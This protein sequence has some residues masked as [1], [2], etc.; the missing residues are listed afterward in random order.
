MKMI[1]EDKVRC[2]QCLENSGIQ[3]IQELGSGSFGVV[4]RVKQVEFNAD[5]EYAMKQIKT[6]SGDI[7]NKLAEALQT[8]HPHCIRF[9]YCFWVKHEGEDFGHTFILME[10][11]SA[12]TL[13]HWIKENRENPDYNLGDMKKWIWQM[14]SALE[15]LNEK[16]VIHRD[17]S[18][19]NVFFA[20]EA[21]YK[22]GGSLKVADYGMIYKSI[23][24]NLP[25]NDYRRSDTQDGAENYTAP[26]V[27]DGHEYNANADV[28]SLGMIAV[29]L[30][31]HVD[32]ME[33][34]SIK[35]QLSAGEI[36]ECLESQDEKFKDF[37]KLATSPSNKRPLANDLIE[38]DFLSGCEVK[39]GIPVY[40]LIDTLHKLEDGHQLSEKEQKIR[41]SVWEKTPFSVTFQDGTV[42]RL[43][44][45]KKAVEELID[46]ETPK[47]LFDA[48]T[49]ILTTVVALTGST[50]VSVQNTVRMPC[51]EEYLKDLNSY[52]DRVKDQNLIFFGLETKS[53]E[54]L[55]E[56][57]K[58]GHVKLIPN[59]VVWM[60]NGCKEFMRSVF[61]TNGKIQFTNGN[62]RFYHMPRKNVLKYENS[63]HNP[64]DVE[65]LSFSKET[66]GLILKAPVPIEP[67]L[68][69]KRIKN[70]SRVITK[71]PIPGVKF[72]DGNVDIGQSYYRLLLAACA[73]IR[74][75]FEHDV[76]L[77]FSFSDDIQKVIWSP[78]N[79]YDFLLPTFDLFVKE[80]VDHWESWTEV[81]SVPLCNRTY[82]FIYHGELDPFESKLLHISLNAAHPYLMELADGARVCIGSPTEAMIILMNQ[83][84]N[85]KGKLQVAMRIKTLQCVL[86]NSTLFSSPEAAFVYFEVTCS[87]YSLDV[88][89]E[90]LFDLLRYAEKLQ[91]HEIVFFGL[92]TKSFA[93]ITAARH[94]KMIPSIEVWM[95]EGC[96]DWIREQIAKEGRIVFPN[97][98][99]QLKWIPRREGLNNHSG[100]F[101][102]KHQH[103][104]ND[105][106][107]SFCQ[108]FQIMVK[109]RVPETA[110]LLADRI[111]SIS[112]H[113]SQEEE[114][115]H[116]I[117]EV[118][119]LKDYLRLLLGACCFAIEKLERGNC[120]NFCF[121]DNMKSVA[122]SMKTVAVHLPTFKV[123]LMEPMEHWESWAEV[124][125]SLWKPEDED[126][127]DED[128]E[129]I[130]EKSHTA[131]FTPNLLADLGITHM[132]HVP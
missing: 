25:V 27:L 33:V 131:L 42:A 67:E 86:T 21:D 52:A 84:V 51:Y 103:D 36:P 130:E 56:S 61:G 35:E 78:Y 1:S 49:R 44:V 11:C 17:L 102:E 41:K 47:N 70:I 73:F 43:G 50:D 18:P 62:A 110:Q 116:E 68:L 121:D 13:Y 100:D 108:R 126:S 83:N 104:E 12:K 99:E 53:L 45:S 88:L 20:T 69:S 40:K 5:K 63:V 4:F 9:E 80:P 65:E 60:M 113:F 127:S 76:E 74:Q 14:L 46:C 26:E 81:F 117:Q 75:K 7:S 48:A 19:D 32:F 132:F 85:N 30:V 22:I 58:N 107:G 115:D 57:Y 39:E 37:L 23:G 72:N 87:K 3:I 31:H 129:L 101:E 124:C 29:E 125:W 82:A 16:G 112:K 55:K 118:E 111:I 6:E 64:L 98:N 71:R 93:G 94:V 106:M 79:L 2:E 34:A 77:D 38:H 66:V 120:V 105:L 24:V 122:T 90:Y 119:K 96:K 109:A 54:K 91:D 59:L 10:L 8:Y 28:F 95:M 97:V 89:L 92:E 128:E 15:W 114:I 123:F